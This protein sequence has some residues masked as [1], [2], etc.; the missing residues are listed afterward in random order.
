MS[1]FA[2]GVLG[3]VIFGIVAVLSM[4]PLEFAISVPPSQPR[5][6]IALPSASPSARPSCRGQ[7]GW[8]A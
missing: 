1:R 6:S 2:V 5:S 4:L 8:W 3:G 7:G